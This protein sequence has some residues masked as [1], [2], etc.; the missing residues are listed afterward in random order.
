MTAVQTANE[1]RIRE[2]ELKQAQQATQIAALE[3]AAVTATATAL[4]AKEQAVN[5]QKSRA[6][7]AAAAKD[8]E[9][10]HL[11]SA[12]AAR[13]LSVHQLEHTVT[14]RTNEVQ[15]AKREAAGAAQRLA[16]VDQQVADCKCG[17]GT[18]NEP[19]EGEG[20]R[21][22]RAKQRRELRTAQ[23]PPSSSTRTVT[24]SGLRRRPRTT[25]CRSPR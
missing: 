6:A 20:G 12:L 22:W 8:E 4:R 23:G 19:T 7:S 14:Q 11:K 1:D 17:K 25:Q 10:A 16:N 3:A 5:V 13:S 24:R 9:I 2:L 18:W 21:Q 15:R